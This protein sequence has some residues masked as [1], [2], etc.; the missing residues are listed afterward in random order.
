MRVESCCGMLFFEY[1]TQYPYIGH[2]VYLQQTSIPSKSC[3]PRRCKGDKA[4]SHRIL[5]HKNLVGEEWAP[6][7]QTGVR[8]VF[9]PKPIQKWT[10]RLPTFPME[11]PSWWILRILHQQH[12]YQKIQ[13][14]ILK[15]VIQIPG[16]RSMSIQHIW[17][18][19]LSWLWFMI[20][21]YSIF[22]K[23]IM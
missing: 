9:P 7:E 10:T 20:Q 16:T 22:K 17:V 4:V 2:Q 19:A 14:V 11:L 6:L 13:K 1:I 18:T 21:L 3:S 23:D 15:Y 5:W 8:R 12:S